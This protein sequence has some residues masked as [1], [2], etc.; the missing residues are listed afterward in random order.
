MMLPVH[1][2]LAKE[3]NVPVIPCPSHG[4]IGNAYHAGVFTV[5]TL[6]VLLNVELRP[7]ETQAAEDKRPDPD[8]TDMSSTAATSAD[9]APKTKRE[10][11]K[12][13]PGIDVDLN[14]C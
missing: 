4:Q 10:C 6:A 5:L 14:I 13:P 8:T 7:T 11:G 12:L 3:A 1:P 2:L 9:K